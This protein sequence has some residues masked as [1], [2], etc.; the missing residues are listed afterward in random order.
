MTSDAPKE[1]LHEGESRHRPIPMIPVAIAA[2]AV[3]AVLLAG[4]LA[5]HA[6]AETNKVALASLPKPV[7]VLPVRKS[8]FASVHTYVGALRPWVEAQSDRSSS[9][10]MSRPCLFG[11][12]RW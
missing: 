5:W 9:P 3:G 12:A 6:E 2:S 1:P 10:P 4:A 11:P 7:T 8:P